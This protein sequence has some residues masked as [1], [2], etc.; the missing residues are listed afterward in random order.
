MQNTH[1]SRR[2][3]LR[4]AGRS[5]RSWCHPV[6]A[7]Q[8]VRPVGRQAELQG[9]R[10]PAGR[11]HV[12][13]RVDAP[14]SRRRDSGPARRGRELHRNV[15]EED[16]GI[17]QAA[18]RP[19]R[20]GQMSEQ[21]KAE[22]AKAAQSVRDAQR[23]W[24][25]SLPMERY[26]QMRRKFNDAGI[27][28]YIAKF[29]PSAWTDE[30]ID[31]A[32]TAAKTLGSIGITDELSDQ[33]CQRLPTF[34]EK[35]KSLAMF[36]THGQVAD[37]GS[38]STGTS[39]FAGQHAQP[40]RRPLLRGDGPPSERCDREVSRPDAQHSYQGQDRTEARNSRTRTS[41]LA[42]AERRSRTFSCCS[43]R[44]SGRSGLTS[45]WSIGFRK[46]PTR[47]RKRRSA[48]TT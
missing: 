10:R 34:A 15:A 25:L 44:K 21:E 13:L 4:A 36:H 39:L 32:Y 11:D 17:P 26:V 12:Q 33:A 29:A 42:R 6:Q 38:L 18:R 3:W 19:A 16:L 27:E 9:G 48:S 5:R 14:Q 47:P 43:R 7:F 40:R 1:L 8:C 41:L 31:Y 2:A 23:Q 30:E 28:V 46:G 20:G 22:F 35:H 24:R 45:S 37:P